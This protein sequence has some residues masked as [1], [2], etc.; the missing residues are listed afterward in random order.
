VVPLVDLTR[1]HRRFGDAFEDASRRVLQS[2]TV[3][4]GVEIAALERELGP[5]L[6]RGGSP[7]DE[8]VAVGSGASGLQLALAALGVGPGDEVIVPAFTAVPT[9]S[10]VCAV[11]AVPVPVDVDPGTAALD[12]DAVAPA[13]TA[14]TR[15]IIVVHLYGRPAPVAPLLAF[16]VPVVE[17]A[18]QAHGALAVVSGAAAVYSFYPTKNVGGIGDGGAVVTSD[19]GLAEKVRRLRVHGMVEQYVHVDIS[20]N[21]RMSEL[22]AAWLRLQ[23]PEL[24]GDNER[25]REI[26]RRYRAAAPGLHWQ[27]DHDD[28]VVHQCV[29]RV[30]DRELARAALLQRGVATGVHY[31]RTIGQQPAYVM[32]ARR[33]CPV[34]ESWAGSCVSLPCSPD[35]RDDEVDHVVSALE[36]IEA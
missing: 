8:V 36:V 6:H 23:L 19:A 18:A 21:H 3:L 35:L 7:D 30:T 14:R 11:G 20:Q 32:F 29:V 10:A 2:G 16:G 4:L 33:A 22:E 34:A 27:L 5:A 1:R 9:A 17:D 31:P 26:A 15:A 24:A 28:H 13:M 25:R 12:P